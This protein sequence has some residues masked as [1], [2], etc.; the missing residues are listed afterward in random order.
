MMGRDDV[1]AGG[2]RADRVTPRPILLFDGACGFCRACVRVFGLLDR[3][4]RVARLDFN[5]PEAD[6]F[7]AAVPPPARRR[8]VLLAVPGGSM[9]SGGPAVRAAL[10]FALGQRALAS[11]LQA[12]PVAALIDAGYALIAD[13]RGW[14]AWLGR[15]GRRCDLNDY[16]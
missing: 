13:R 1:E 7:L 9:R 12:R 3:R 11:M 10:E 14:F 4:R 5:R 6:E 2:A 15:F 16:P 8:A